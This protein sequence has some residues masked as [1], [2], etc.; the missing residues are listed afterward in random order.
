MAQFDVHRNTGK[1]RDP[2]PFVVLV[3]MVINES[4]NLGPLI[5]ETSAQVRA[6]YHVTVYPW[7]QSLVPIVNRLPFLPNITGDQIQ[8]STSQY[9]GEFV[10]Q[11]GPKSGQSRTERESYSHRQD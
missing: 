3:G 9:A 6:W 2:I 8:E 1:M 10:G 11:A 4:G 7:L 5:Q